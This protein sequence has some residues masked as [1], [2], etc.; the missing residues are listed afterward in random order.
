MHE[1][2]LATSVLSVLR[3]SPGPHRLVRVHVGDVSSPAPELAERIQ[4]YLDAARP[5]VAVGAVEVVLRPR[6]RLCSSCAATWNSP[7]PAPSCP[8]CGGAPMP[9]PHDHQLEIELI[10]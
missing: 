8:D 6:H 7:E 9:L 10:T 4:T 1:S 3:G 2:G 5:P